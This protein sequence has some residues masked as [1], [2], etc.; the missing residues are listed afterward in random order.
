M[1]LFQLLLGSIFCILLGCEHEE[2]TPEQ[3]LNK[4]RSPVVVISQGGDWFSG[5]TI[6]VKDANDSI[7]FMRSPAFE[8][9]QIGDTLK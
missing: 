3:T 2:E 9:L 7:V 1:K 6:Y 5:Y 8:S 4:L